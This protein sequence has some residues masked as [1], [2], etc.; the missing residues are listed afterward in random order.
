MVHSDHFQ[1]F[2]W[3][4]RPIFPYPSP[5]PI[6]ASSTPDREWVGV[7]FKEMASRGT[8][9]FDLSLFAQNGT[10]FVTSELTMAERAVELLGRDER[11]DHDRTRPDRTGPNWNTCSPGPAT[12]IPFAQRRPTGGTRLIGCGRRS[13]V[14]RSKFPE[15]GRH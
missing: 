13:V 5:R 4:R 9:D 7:R 8:N 6:G 1:F 15:S 2:A 11:R 14:D 3:N 12:T 10:V